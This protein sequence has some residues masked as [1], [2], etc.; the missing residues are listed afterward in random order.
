MLNQFSL[1]HNEK[2]SI[3]LCVP[4]FTAMLAY[5]KDSKQPN[6]SPDG[7]WS[8][9]LTFALGLRLGSQFHLVCLPF[10]HVGYAMQ[11]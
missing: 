10:L 2:A 6:V 11:T 1:I 7:I 9:W 4:E 8:R 5:I 3:H